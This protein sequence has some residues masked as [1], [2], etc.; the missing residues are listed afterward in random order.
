MTR[1]GPAALVSLLTLLG[2]GGATAPVDVRS[3][4]ADLWRERDRLFLRHDGRPAREPGLVPPGTR[5][6]V[7]R[8]SALVR[9]R[10][11]PGRWTLLELELGGTAGERLLLGWAGTDPSAWGPLTLTGRRAERVALPLPQSPAD[12]VVR[13]AQG[14]LQ[15]PIDFGRVWLVDD[16]KRLWPP[17]EPSEQASDVQAWAGA[18]EWTVERVAGVWHV[19]RLRFPGAWEVVEVNGVRALLSAAGGE[20]AAVYASGRVIRTGQ[21][22]PA[23]GAETNPPRWTV[24]LDDDHGRLVRTS[25]GDADAT[26][27]DAMRGVVV[28]EA[29]ARAAAAASAGGGAASAG[30]GVRRMVLFVEPV[31]AEAVSRPAVEVRGLAAGAV[32]VLWEGVLVRSVARLPDGTVLFEL[33]GEVSARPGEAGRLG[34]RVELLVGD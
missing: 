28:V 29:G 21:D 11:W 16:R 20:G 19:G 9:G 14:S 18:A 31:G 22:G 23:S 4:L 2:P 15:R 25:P 3:E 5:E 8:V 27:F 13:S 30:G 1:V 34:G 32:R 6:A 24:R 33:P 17:D 26:G 7:V 12:L 10:E